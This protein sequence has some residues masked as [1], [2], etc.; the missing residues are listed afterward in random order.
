MSCLMMVTT[1]MREKQ[2]S[3]TITNIDDVKAQ[4]VRDA[5]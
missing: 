2:Q 1:P 5:F 3:V 4:G